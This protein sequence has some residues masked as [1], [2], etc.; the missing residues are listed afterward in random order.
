MFVSRRTSRTL[1]LPRQHRTRNN[2]REHQREQRRELAKLLYQGRKG[3]RVFRCCSRAQRY[4]IVTVTFALDANFACTEIR[5]RSERLATCRSA[6]PEPPTSA[7]SAS[8]RSQRCAPH[9]LG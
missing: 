5:T 4:G 2:L 1:S 3:R 8:C 7:G 9:I 6:Q